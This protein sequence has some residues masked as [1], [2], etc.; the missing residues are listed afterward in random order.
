MT[1]EVIFNFAMNSLLADFPQM[2][3]QF[4]QFFLLSFFWKLPC[5]FKLHWKLL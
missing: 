5:L 3:I 1:T 2:S 4:S